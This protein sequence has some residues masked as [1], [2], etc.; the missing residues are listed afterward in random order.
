MYIQ[1]KQNSAFT[2]YTRPAQRLQLSTFA[3]PHNEHSQIFPQASVPMITSHFNLAYQIHN[4]GQY[5][6][7]P[8]ISGAD[9][10]LFGASK[11]VAYTHYPLLQVNKTEI[12]AAPA[13]SASAGLHQNAI[14]ID[15]VANTEQHEEEVHVALPQQPSK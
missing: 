10:D 12:R 9:E 4:F 13:M 14:K 5:S 6:H 3:Q 1:S 2:P 7:Q 15:E 8:R 11:V